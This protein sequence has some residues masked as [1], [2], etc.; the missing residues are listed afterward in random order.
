MKLVVDSNIIFSAIISPTGKT[1]ELL[2]LED[3]ELYSARTLEI[4]LLGHKKEIMRKAHFREEQFE[5]LMLIFLGKITFLENAE[6][7]TVI[8]DAK[9]ICPDVGDIAFF[10]VCLAKNLPLWSNDKKLK[11]QTVVQVISIE[12]LV[13]MV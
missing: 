5:L 2:L 4:E 9:K 10:A 1:A 3:I 11:N 8:G 7:Y 12:E 13:K 6:L